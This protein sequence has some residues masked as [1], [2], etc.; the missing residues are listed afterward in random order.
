MVEEPWNNGGP[1]GNGGSGIVVVRYQIGQ[2]ATDAKA[3]GGSISY[4]N[5]KTIHT[6]TG[7][8]VFNNTSGSTLTAEVLLVGGGG[9][10]GIDAAGGGGAGGFVYYP[11]MSITTG[12]KSTVVVGSGGAQAFKPGAGPSAIQGVPTTFNGGTGW[13]VAVQHQME[14]ILQMLLVLVVAVMVLVDNL[15][16][17]QQ[18]VVVLQ[19]NQD[20]QTLEHLLM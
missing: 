16:H 13:V 11:G 10:G 18:M 19:H 20:N 7:S 4:Y 14:M 1:G 17:N 5:N 6:F 15:H 3:T 8:G 9:A 2:I 12:P